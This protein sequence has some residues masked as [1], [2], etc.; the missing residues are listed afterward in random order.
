MKVL[1]ALRDRFSR[2]AGPAGE[3]DEAKFPIARYD[4]LNAKRVTKKLPQQSQIELDAIETH[5][6]SHKDRPVV[7]QRLRYLQGPEPLQGYDALDDDD[8][9]AADIAAALEGADVKTLDAVRDYERKHRR[10]TVVLEEVGRARREFRSTHAEQ[11]AGEARDE[12]RDLETM[13]KLEAGDAPTDLKDWPSDSAMY[14][15][16]GS[17]DDQPYGEGQTAK[18]GPSELTRH[19]D[20]SISIKGK[21]VDNPDDH[22][23]EPIPGGPTDPNSPKLSGERRRAGGPRDEERDVETMRTLEAGDAPADLKDWPSDS[24][25][26]KTYGSED[27]QPYGEGQTAKLGPSE[28]RRHDDGSISIKGKKVDNPEDYKGEP[29]PGGPT[30]PNR[31]QAPAPS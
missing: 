14:K 20:G 15:T 2:G 27:D 16:Y 29:I 3:G 19:D 26:Y 13:R 11:A 8:I 28:L 18:L 12:E 1:N 5:E 25:M 23:G 4:G 6:R 17:E 24:A 7:L 21:K 9:S 22:K 10:R 31:P 30:D